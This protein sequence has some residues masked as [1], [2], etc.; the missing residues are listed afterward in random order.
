MGCRPGPV[1]DHVAGF[2]GRFT[3]RIRENIVTAIEQRELP[4]DD[5]PDALTFELS[6]ILLAANANFVLRDDAAALDLAKRI[7]RRR[8]GLATMTASQN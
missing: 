8:L 1:R 4:E 7:V 5:D 6:G 3:G 2:Q